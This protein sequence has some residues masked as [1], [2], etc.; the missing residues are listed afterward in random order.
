MTWKDAGF[1]LRCKIVLNLVRGESVQKMSTILGCS[2]SQ[3]YRVA[4]RFVQQDV[5]GLA[6]RREDKSTQ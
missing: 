3:V 2:R 6:D 5:V 1:C 4:W